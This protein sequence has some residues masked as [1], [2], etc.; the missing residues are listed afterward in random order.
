[1]E[2]KL[3]KKERL[4]KE[5]QELETE[6]VEEPED[7]GIQR[8]KEDIEVAQTTE[9]IT[10]VKKPR[11]EAQ[12]KAFEKARENARLNAEKRKAEREIKALEERKE[13]EEKLVKK[14]ISIKKKQIKQQ[15][16]LDEISDDDTPLIEIQKIVKQLPSKTRSKTALEL[17]LKKEPSPYIFF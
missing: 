7:L 16:V 2:S 10:K 17:P 15:A 3:S 1:M 4:L 8:G 14:A 6:D 5:L 9:S 12:L 11:T 13:V